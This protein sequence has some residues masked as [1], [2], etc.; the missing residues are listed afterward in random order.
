M[1][2]R[3]ACRRGSTHSLSKPSSSSD[4][5]I[6]YIK[7]QNGSRRQSRDSGS[8]PRRNGTGIKSGTKLDWLDQGHVLSLRIGLALGQSINHTCP[9]FGHHSRIMVVLTTLF[10]A[11][12]LRRVVEV[13]CNNSPEGRCNKQGCEYNHDPA[14]V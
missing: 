3:N 9:P 8:V 10:V 6:S 7:Q 12:A 14:H 2:F 4:P 1:C 11:T 5:N 13:C